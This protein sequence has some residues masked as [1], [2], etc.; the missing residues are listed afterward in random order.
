MI[1]ELTARMV[2]VEPTFSSFEGAVG[3][4]LASPRSSRAIADNESMREVSIQDFAL[5]RERVRFL[6]SDGRVLTVFRDGD[7]V[8]WAFTNEPFVPMESPYAE[9]VTRWMESDDGPRSFPWRPDQLLR[10]RL[11]VPRIRLAPTVTWLSLYVRGREDVMFFQVETPEGA[12]FLEFG[13]E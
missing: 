9:E 11:G 3:A 8:D 5:E 2:F 12:R 6:L 7:V 13:E 4:T 1:H 10:E